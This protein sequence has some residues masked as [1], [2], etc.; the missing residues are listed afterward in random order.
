[1]GKA[2]QKS[3]FQVIMAVLAMVMVTSLIIKHPL[4][5]QAE[6]RNSFSTD[7]MNCYTQWIAAILNPTPCTFCYLSP[8]L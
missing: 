2:Y 5:T 7:N 3:D 4:L 6:N 1:M 8:I